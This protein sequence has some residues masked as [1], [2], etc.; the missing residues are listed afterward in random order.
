MIHAAAAHKDRRYF[1]VFCRLIVLF[2]K[3]IEIS[4]RLVAESGFLFY[5]VS[6]G[7]SHY[8]AVCRCVGCME[9]TQRSVF[10][11]PADLVF[12]PD[13]LNKSLRVFSRN[14]E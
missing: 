11:E 14:R 12:L 3:R 10:A 4:E 13:D 8:G 6:I 7:K 5:A 9:N 2:C 1:N